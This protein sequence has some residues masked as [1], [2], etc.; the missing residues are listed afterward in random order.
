MSTNATLGEVRIYLDTRKAQGFNSFYLM[1]MV[2]PGGYG[3]AP[4]A[5][6]NRAGDPPF[7]TPNV[8][9]T[10]GGS[11]G[12]ARYWSWIDSIVDEAAQRSMV[13]MLAYTYLGYAGGDQGWYATL[14]AQPS[15]QAC[16]DWGTW[17]GNRY[18]DKPNVIWFAL[19]D[20]TP[21]SGSEG[22]AR[23]LAIIDGIKAAGAT[24]PFMAEPSGGDSNP[25]LDAPAFASRLDLNSFYGYGPTGRGDCYLQ[26][27]RAYQVSPAKPAW[28]Q[29]GGY[30]FENNTGGF[31]GQPYETRRTRL[32]SVLSGGTSGDGFGTRDVYQWLSLPASLSTPG[33]T[34]SRHAFNLFASLPWWDLRPSGTGTGFAGRTLVTSGAGTKGGMDYVTSAVTSDGNYLL[35]YVPTTGGS[36]A[37]TI[38]VDMAALSRPALASW[39][40]PATGTSTSIGAGFANSGTRSFTSPGVNG[41]GQNDWVLLVDAV[42]AARCGTISPSG[43]YSA[44]PVVPV[45]VTC[46]VS[47]ALQSDPAAVARAQVILH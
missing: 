22:E 14:L 41:G 32:W 7:A 13:V 36:A 9:S 18:K 20:F 15:R 43:L 17:L 47:A 35:A 6:N 11:A 1:A 25:I 28:V 12:S 5:P 31:T 4:N 37:R 24:Q 27:E 3:A 39:W 23:A 2:H 38:T 29:E 34:F 44:P 19:G 46:H 33:A 8:F 42:G 16:T 26:A 21:P 45:D 30:E 40:D 10:A